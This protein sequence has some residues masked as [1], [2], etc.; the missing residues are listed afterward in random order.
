MF[1]AMP[2]T[3]P[4]DTVSRS[5]VL[6]LKFHF[7]LDGRSFELSNFMFP[8]CSLQFLFWSKTRTLM[9]SYAA[10]VR[11]F[12]TLEDTLVGYMFNDLIWCGQEE[13]SGT[14]FI[15]LTRQRRLKHN[16][17]GTVFSKKKKSEYQRKVWQQQN[18]K[19]NLLSCPINYDTSTPIYLKSCWETVQ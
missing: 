5:D 13:D 16:K 18:K 12:W 14:S 6:S 3:W 9:H 4:C 8:F 19:K 10:V 11:H 1:Y 2:Q 7:L 17:R 15:V